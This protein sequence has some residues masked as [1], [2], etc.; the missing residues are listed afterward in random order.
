MEQVAT[1]QATG[2]GVE[3]IPAPLHVL[4][5]MR[6]NPSAEQL[7]AGVHG[8]AAGRAHM[9]APSQV[10]APIF[11]LESIEQVGAPHISP[12]W[13]WQA[14]PLAAHRALDPHG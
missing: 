13:V 10:P 5:G 8:T 2:A 7:A 6:D 11:E 4:A 9:P 3:Q 14:V 1:G 12:I